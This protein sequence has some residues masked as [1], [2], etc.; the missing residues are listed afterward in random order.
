ME[1]LKAFCPLQNLDN[2]SIHP[3]VHVPTRELHCAE[4]EER[5]VG[6]PVHPHLTP[7]APQWFLT[8]DPLT[9]GC[10]EDAVLVSAYVTT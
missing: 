3:T 8:G 1:I 4:S 7:Q 2:P 6:D 10:S 9:E 5:E